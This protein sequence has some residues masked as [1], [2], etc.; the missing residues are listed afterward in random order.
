MSLTGSMLPAGL[1]AWAVGLTAVAALGFGAEAS[2]PEAYDVVIVGGTPGGIMAAIA[3]ARGGCTAVVLDRNRHIGGLPANGLGATDIHTRGATQ[4]LFMEFIT[5]VRAHYATTYGEDSRQV[6]QCSD[7]YRFE[8]SVAE[9]I[10]EQMLAEHKDRIA[11]RRRRQFHALAG[12][13]VKEGAA[14]RQITVLNRDTGAP[15]RYAGKVFIDATYEGDLAA[16]AGAYF[17]AA[18]LMRMSELRDLFGRRIHP[19]R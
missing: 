18:W 3:A 7:G 8:P 5:R 17:A 16:A 2:R 15:E 11:V 6:R 19:D 4:G 12:S 13:V 9:R 14:V 1:F 10:F